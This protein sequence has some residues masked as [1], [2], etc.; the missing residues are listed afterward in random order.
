[1]LL[2][3]LCPGC[4]RTG[5]SPCAMCVAGMVP[6]RPVPVPPSFDRCC[7]LLDYEGAAREVVAQLKYRNVRS[8][9]GWLGRG[10][11]GLVA[12]GE[13]ELVTWA[14]TTELRRRRRGFD[15]A[16]LLARRVARELGLP[17]RALLTRAPGPPQTGRSLLDRH[18]GPAFLPTRYVNSRRIVVVDDVVT[19]GATLE[20]AGRALRAAGAGHLVGLAAAHPA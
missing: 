8:P 11:A 12:V 13:V 7:A 20:A 16:E 6:S 1:M 19:T 10:M 17:C 3:T 5:A 9:V 14:P 18:G 15:H 4:G 2:A